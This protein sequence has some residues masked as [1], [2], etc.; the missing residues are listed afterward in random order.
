MC[1]KNQVNKI[2]Y[3]SVYF[4]WRK[5]MLIRNTYLYIECILSWKKLLFCC[6]NKKYG[7]TQKKLFH[8]LK[9]GGRE[10]F[11][12][13][14]CVRVARLYSSVCVA[15]SFTFIPLSYRNIWP[16]KIG[17]PR[18]NELYGCDEGKCGHPNRW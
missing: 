5:N 18:P 10:V 6:Q 15:I 3:E 14:V 8:T 12:V 2:C 4:L 13:C 11:L 16:Q 1:L 17:M 7:K 9:H